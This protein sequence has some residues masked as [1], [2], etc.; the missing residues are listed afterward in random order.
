M[1]NTEPSITDITGT[2][3]WRRGRVEGWVGVDEI[4]VERYIKME[5]AGERERERERQRESEREKARERARERESER[6]SERDM[7]HEN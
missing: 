4:D 7:P 5:E 2:D 6:E 3:T 1:I